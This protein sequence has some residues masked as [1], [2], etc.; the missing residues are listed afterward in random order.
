MNHTEI[1]D[2]RSDTVT[3]PSPQMW[4]RVRSMSNSD[5]GDDVMHEDP[6]INKLEDEAARIMGKEAALL[7]TSGTQGNLLSL[8]SHTDPGD[9][10]LVEEKAHIYAHEVGG[11]ARI[12][13]VMLRTYPS[14]KGLPD[15][16]ELQELIR[17]KED[18]HEPPTTLLCTEDTHNSH[19]GV[20]IRPDKLH[21]LYEFARD[22]ELKLHID[23]ARIFNASVASGI[24]VSKFAQHADSVM[25]CLSKGLSC[26]VGSMIVGDQDFI[27]RA[28]KFRKMVGGGMRQAGIIA[29]FGLEALRS[30]WINRLKE[31][32]RLAEILANGLSDLSYPIKIQEPQT[33]ILMVNFPKHIEMN[34]VVKSLRENGVLAFDDGHRIRF[35]THYGISEEQ[36]YTAIGYVDNA[37]QKIFPK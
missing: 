35:V 26:P 8:L 33:N 17:N 18:I 32:H 13:G 2:L 37:L 9:E 5:L 25:F 6:T 16:F 34:L 21:E 22:N 12:A 30:D 3:K 7:V 19:G 24:H 36:I 27:K 4:E 28:R 14:D 1:I 20:V 15:L 23:G 31:D 11:A 10:I 29:A